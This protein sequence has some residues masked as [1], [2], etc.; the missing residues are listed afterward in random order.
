MVSAS[1]YARPPNVVRDGDAAV[2][3][4]MSMPVGLRQTAGAERRPQR[5]Q[6]MGAAGVY[7]DRI[8]DN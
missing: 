8:V 5:L 2:S 1:G 6:F 3:T 7:S 4:V